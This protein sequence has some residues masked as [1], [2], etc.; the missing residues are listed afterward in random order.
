MKLG[1]QLYS[2]RN[3]I[4][5]DVP[6]A[7]E[8][9]ADIGFKTVEFAGYYGIEAREM[10]K[11]LDGCGLKAVSTHI[12][13]KDIGEG[14]EKQIEY[15]LEVGNRTLIV[16]WSDMK[17]TEACKAIS[18]QINAAVKT[19]EKYGVALGY[20]NHAHEFAPIGQGRRMIDLFA[21]E[22]AESLKFEFDVYWAAFAGADP[23][24]YVKKYAGRQTHMH[25]K[26]MAE[27]PRRNVELGDGVIDFK[28][29]ITEGKKAGVREFILEQEEYTMPPMESCRR[30]FEGAKK[31]GLL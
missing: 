12:G 22:T 7:L 1:L 8:K 18:E 4:E 28:T 16:A 15:N 11:L 13:M 30:S 27:D 9:V 19:C 23:A 5:K 6:A 26:E 21:E 25:L 10:K 14:L 20:H 2:L 31:L 24:E 17:S 3:V 29:L